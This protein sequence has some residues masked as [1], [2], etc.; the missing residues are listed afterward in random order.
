[1][2]LKK[3]SLEIF[4]QKMCNKTLPNNSLRNCVAKNDRTKRLSRKLPLETFVKE[5]CNTMLPKKLMKSAT[6]NNPIEK[7]FEKTIV[8]NVRQKYA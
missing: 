3:L 2:L 4:V 5:R 6:R 1:M 8:R 7:L